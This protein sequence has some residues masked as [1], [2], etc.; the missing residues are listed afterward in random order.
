MKKLDRTDQGVRLPDGRYFGSMMV[1]HHLHCLVGCLPSDFN[2]GS[3]LTERLAYRN[4]YTTPCILN[5][6]GW[7]TRLVTKLWHCANILVRLERHQSKR[8]ETR[9][10]ALEHCMGA[11]KAYIMC[12]AD[13]TIETMLWDNKKLLPLHNVTST[14][15]CVS[16]DSIL[17][18]AKDNN[19]DVRAEGML[20]HPVYGA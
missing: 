7:P 20:V 3:S 2:C 6:T 11:L 10:T 5:P 4:T 8:A 9:L 1:Y 13:T 17:N 15:K 16:W 12:Q 18:Y 19:V 14:Q